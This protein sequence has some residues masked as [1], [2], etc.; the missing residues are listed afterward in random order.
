VFTTVSAEQVGRPLKLTEMPLKTDLVVWIPLTHYQTAIYKYM[1]QNQ[2]LQRMIKDRAI[3]SA[4]HI[5]CYLKK[6]CL[7]PSLLAGTSLQKKKEIG[8]ISAEEEA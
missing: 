6:M 5:L 2:S 1:L 3:T 8:I 4:F 7:H